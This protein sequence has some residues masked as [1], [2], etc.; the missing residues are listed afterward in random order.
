MPGGTTFCSTAVRRLLDACSR[1][2][3]VCSMEAFSPGCGPMDKFETIV[4]SLPEKSARSRLDPYADL[5]K[6]LLVRGWTYR[7]IARILFEKCGVRIS[8]SSIHHFVH[9]RSRSKCKPAKSRSRNLEQKTAIPTDRNG[10]NEIP[11]GGKE[12]PVNNEAY[13]RIAAL[14]QRP[15]L[16]KESSKPFHYDPDEPLHLPQKK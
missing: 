11:S 8:F 12:I 15:A 3:D 5:I 14:K 6:E 16:P 13:Q 1:L 10:R 9:A 7:E 2:F 4:N